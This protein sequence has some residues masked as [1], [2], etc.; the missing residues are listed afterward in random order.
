MGHQRRHRQS[1]TQHAHAEREATDR[2]TDD[3]FLL[4]DDRAEILAGARP[5]RITW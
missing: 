3:G 4:V 1:T 5:E 2:L